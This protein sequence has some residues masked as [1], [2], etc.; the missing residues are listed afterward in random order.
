MVFCSVIM[1]YL[2]YHMI[3]KAVNDGKVIGGED[4]PVVYEA[5]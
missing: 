3:R 4:N 1:V 5:L 2:F